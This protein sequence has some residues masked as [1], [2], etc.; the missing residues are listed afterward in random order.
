MLE[1]LEK[2]LSELAKTLNRLGDKVESLS[3]DSNAFALNLEIVADDAKYAVMHCNID[4]TNKKLINVVVLDL[5][6]MQLKVAWGEIAQVYFHKTLMFYDEIFVPGERFYYFLKR[7]IEDA[8][9]L[10]ED[11]INKIEYVST[12]LYFA[13]YYLRVQLGLKEKFDI[14]DIYSKLIKAGKKNTAIKICI[15][16]SFLRIL[17]AIV[18]LIFQDARIKMDRIRPKFLEKNVFRIHHSDKEDVQNALKSEQKTIDE[19]SQS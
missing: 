1:S 7:W 6:S 4:T 11:L 10:D 14:V 13:G 5:Q 19:V 16:Y 17:E 12:D 15:L 2:A 9:N 8:M 3:A 18:S